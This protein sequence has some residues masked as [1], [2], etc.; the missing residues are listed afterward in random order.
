MSYMSGTLV[1][2]NLMRE[3]EREKERWKVR[4]I[5]LERVGEL[6]RERMRE[7][8]SIKAALSK[9]MKRLVA[10][11]GETLETNLCVLTE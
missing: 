4:E 7:I 1:K 5:E 11:S 10:M 3:I 2:S 9:N 8:D 6:E